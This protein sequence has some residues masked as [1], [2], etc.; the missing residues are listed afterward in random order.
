MPE[1]VR[2]G[3]IGVGSIGR[4]HARIYAESPAADLVG[5][6]DIQLDRAEEIARS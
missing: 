4:H 1:P 5:V 3:V 6:H 2:V